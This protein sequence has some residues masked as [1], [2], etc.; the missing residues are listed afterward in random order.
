MAPRAR[1]L[2]ES[3][4]VGGE[5]G[6]HARTL[7]G[8]ELVVTAVEAVIHVVVDRVKPGQRAGVPTLRAS[9]GRAA[10]RRRVAHLVVRVGA[11]TLERVVQ[12]KPVAGLVGGGLTEVEVGLGSPGQRGVLHPNSVDARLLGVV[13]GEGRDA[14]DGIEVDQ[15]DV[16]R[17]RAAP[18]SLGAVR[19]AGLVLVPGGVEVAVGPGEPERETGV[20]G[21]GWLS[22]AVGLVQ[23]RDLL[24]DLGVDD[25]A[26]APGLGHHVDVHRDR[27]TAHHRRRAR[28]STLLCLAIEDRLGAL[29]DRRALP[30]GEVTVLDSVTSTLGSRSSRLRVEAGAGSVAGRFHGLGGVHGTDDR[31]AADERRD[32]RCSDRPVTKPDH[33]DLLRGG[34]LRVAEAP[35]LDWILSDAPPAREVERRRLLCRFTQVP[36]YAKCGADLSPAPSGQLAERHLSTTSYT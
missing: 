7:A 32:P 15:P 21:G 6:V 30:R 19:R 11:A 28:C 10:L 4:A 18:A 5:H 31:E 9:A 36:V 3:G 14:Q 35:S 17:V 20:R 26:V 33:G 34:L 16:Q 13:P 2:R 29:L 8:G 12:P 27:G 22:A 25:V 24:A 1:L 23:H